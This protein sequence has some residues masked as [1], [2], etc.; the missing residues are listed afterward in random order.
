MRALKRLV[1]TSLEM[2][3]EAISWGLLVGVLT[4]GQGERFTYVVMGSILALPVALFL[5]GYYFTRIFTGM[6]LRS[7]GR[8]FYPM[9]A[10][11]AFV[12]HASVLLVRLKPDLNF[13]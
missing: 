8:W 10:C 12:V 4:V 5:Y 11:A 6:V 2:A 1:V 3:A 9:I 13:L 7:G